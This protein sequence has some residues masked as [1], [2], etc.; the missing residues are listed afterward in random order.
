M[1]QSGQGQSKVRDLLEVS[2]AD[3]YTQL[4]LQKRIAV[5]PN[6]SGGGE[7]GGGGRDLLSQ[8]ELFK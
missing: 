5:N 3:L 8:Q 6:G 1:G 4:R 2:W 7:G